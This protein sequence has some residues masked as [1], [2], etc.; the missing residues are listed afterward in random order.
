M[1]KD[2]I[3][4]TVIGDPISKKTGFILQKANTD[5]TTVE[6]YYKAVITLKDKSSLKVK[7]WDTSG[8]DDFKSLRDRYIDS[9]DA[10]IVIFSLTDRYSFKHAEESLKEISLLNGS[11]LKA[12]LVGNDCNSPNRQLKYDDGKKLADD[13]NIRY[14]EV[15]SD[16][17][18]N[19]EEVFQLLGSYFLS[20]E[21][22]SKKK[23]RI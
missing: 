10:F 6:D 13:Y 12:V 8:Q 15:S 20:E 18:L 4:I 19:V 2:V 22:S 21:P 1:I 9:A 17:N 7:I 11:N 3:N 5:D 16:D 23:C 14:I